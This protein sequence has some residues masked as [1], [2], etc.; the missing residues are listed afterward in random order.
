MKKTQQILGLPVIAVSSGSQLGSVAGI[1]VNPEQGSV[2]C[3][4]LDRENWYGEMRALPYGAVLGIG[5]FAVTILNSGD[6]FPVSVK[7]ELVSILERDVQI[8][9]AGVLTRAGKYIGTVSE[10]IIDD[11]SGK[12]TGCQVVTDDGGDFIVPGEKVLTYGSK[13]LVIEDGH[14]GYVVKELSEGKPAGAAGNV[15][16]RS[17]QSAA[18]GKNTASGDPVEVFEARQRQYLAGKKATKKITGTGGQV[19]VEEGEVI[20]EEIIEKALAM[21]K[22]I[23]LTMNV[24]D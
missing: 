18:R 23:E 9:K 21:D 13:F 16:T 7:P 1:A 8:I 4:L 10:Y 24:A 12:I 22:Y 6:A 15:S 19:I 5:E 20:T 2:E 3:L 14:E 17:S 11:Q